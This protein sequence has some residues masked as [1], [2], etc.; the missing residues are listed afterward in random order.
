MKKNLVP[1]KKALIKIGLI[2]LFIMSFINFCGVL[3]C[4]SELLQA[5][6][7]IKEDEN[8]IAYTELLSFIFYIVLLLL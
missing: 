6:I 5:I 8:L 4:N 7:N 3:L 1:N 2:Y